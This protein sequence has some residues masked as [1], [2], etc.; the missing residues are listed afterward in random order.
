[1][2][3]WLSFKLTDYALVQQVAIV[4]ATIA[5]IDKD[6]GTVTLRSAD[7]ELTTIKARHP[8][9]L[10]RVVVGDLVE[11]TYTEA[12]AVSVETPQQ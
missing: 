4:T 7:G 3:S 8:E 12:L 11:I 5:A 2:K 6:A 10:E 1:M 9:N